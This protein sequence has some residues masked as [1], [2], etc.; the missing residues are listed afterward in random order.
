MKKKL[1]PEQLEKRKKTNSKILKYGCLPILVFFIIVM[2]LV[3]N[4]DDKKITS[5]RSNINMDSVVSLVG[6]S[7]DFEIKEVYYDKKDS[8]FN[9]AITNKDNVIKEHS[10]SIEYF[11]KFYGLNSINEIEGIYLYEYK[12]GK[13]FKNKDYKEYLICDSKNLSKRIEKFE[14]SGYEYDIK[15]YLEKN[16]DDPTDLEIIKK[17]VIRAN[18]DGTF[19]VKV[20][21]RSKNAF[22]AFVIHTMNCDLDEEGNGKNIVF[23]N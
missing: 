10:Y 4:S 19:S 5:V 23:D 20:V 14:E 2:M 15:S 9:I 22:G 1:T 16:I 17:D 3:N 18:E 13:S 7:K 6:K 12:K 21:F 8:S 11:N